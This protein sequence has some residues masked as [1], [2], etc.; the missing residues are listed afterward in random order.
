M[1][2]RPAGKYEIAVQPDKLQINGRNAS[3][4]GFETVVV[5]PLISRS[6]P[7]AFAWA[8]ITSPVRRPEGVDLGPLDRLKPAG[9][10]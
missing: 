1:E 10:A 5:T 3:D 8:R 4:T 9:W 6:Q 2:R 7:N